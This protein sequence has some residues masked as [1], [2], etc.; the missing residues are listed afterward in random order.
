MSLLRKL[1][2]EIQIA[3]RYTSAKRH[4]HRNSFISFISL[5]SVVGIA[6]GVA[7]L[8]VVLSVMNGFQK[9]VA[10]R[11]LSM[12]PH[13]EVADERGVFADWQQTLT[14]AQRNPAVA[15]GAPFVALQG[16]LVYEETMA[17]A[18]IHGI[19]PDA[20]RRVSRVAERMTSGALTDL[21][22]ASFGIVLG[23]ELANKLG[24]K[25]GDKLTLI[26]APQAGAAD[27]GAPRRRLLTVAGLFN[28][29]H[30]DYD[31]GAALMHIGDAQELEGLPGP[32]GLRLSLH[33][34]H[35]APQVAYELTRSMPQGLMF[36]DWSK[37]NEI[38]F[39]A[40]RTQKKM[41][42]IILTLIV[43][44]AAFN[45][46][47]TLVMK[48]NDKQADIAILR[49]L[50]ASP[51]SIVKIFMLQGALVGMIGSACGVAAGVLVALNVDVIMP[52]VEKA[53]GSK[54]LSKEI[55]FLSSVPSDLQWGDVGLI[56]A[57]SVALSF[58][59]T[60]Y[61]SFSASRVNPAQSLRYE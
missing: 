8:I 31:S 34:L 29:G 13:I 11:M 10:N 53:L 21:A 14:L 12:V 26:L 51:A 49:T 7:A 35:Q 2:Y 30:N 6:L 24:V 56:A 19:L 60:L 32:S 48:V 33:D 17:P 50:G 9:E 39:A 23:Y 41:M 27:A 55:Y 15:G 3:L 43:A 46:V 44:V 38:W 36:R 47:S 28:V 52:V 45:L 4:S 37:Q 22:P 58:L 25:R 54:L 1:P 20:E 5:I 59:A 16:M 40:L 18:G 61:P 57:V 42:F